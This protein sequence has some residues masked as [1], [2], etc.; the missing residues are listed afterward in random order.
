MS[1][2][3]SEMGKT[4]NRGCCCMCG[5]LN[6]LILPVISGTMLRRLA[7]YIPQRNTTF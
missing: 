4:D 7:S 6:A 5:E 1:A 2:S 3:K